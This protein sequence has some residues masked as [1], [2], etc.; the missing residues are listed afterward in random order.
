MITAGDEL[1]RT[2]FGDWDRALRA[3][4][5]RINRL[6]STWDPDSELSRFNRSTSLQPFL[7][8]PE[9]PRTG[10]PLTQAGIS[11]RHRH[12]RGSRSAPAR[13]TPR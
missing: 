7:L 10:R 8:S 5:A 1:E 9:D 11:H 12:A 2:G 4:L 3:S 13:S 6:M